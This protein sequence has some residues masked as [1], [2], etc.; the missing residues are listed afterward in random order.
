MLNDFDIDK[1][2]YSY[3]FQFL[4]IPPIFVIGLRQ[5]KEMDHDLIK[6]WKQNELSCMIKFLPRQIRGWEYA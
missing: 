5:M 3:N 2:K 1:D 4:R 6:T